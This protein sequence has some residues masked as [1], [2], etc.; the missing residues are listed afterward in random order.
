M[1]EVR[2][3]ITA[4]RRAPLKSGQMRV[5]G[6]VT[7]THV[8]VQGDRRF[9]L[10]DPDSLEM[11]TLRDGSADMRRMLVALSVSED[12]RWVRFRNTAA[13]GGA[14]QIT[15]DLTS[16]GDYQEV[17]VVVHG[18]ARQALRLGRT[19]PDWLEARFGI[20]CLVVMADP[21]WLSHD[22]KADKGTLEDEYGRIAFADAG[23]VSFVTRDA[24]QELARR[25]GI[26]G[27]LEVLRRLRTN[28]VIE[29]VTQAQLDTCLEI[30]IGQAQFRRI[31]AQHRCSVVDVA[32]NG[33]VGFEVRRAL[34]D[35]RR[36]S[37]LAPD[38]IRAGA[39]EVDPQDAK[40][41]WIATRGVRINGGQ[42][43]T[44][45]GQA[46]TLVMPEP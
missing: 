2:G 20:R 38:V 9:M 36:G 18:K 11:I 24:L 6:N 4:L 7:F 29:D 31:G 32:L 22:S 40:R 45:V 34:A 25:S 16:R 19:L 17:E 33:N 42:V 43:V 37:H 12:Q 15:L 26:D 3:H 28:V 27:E 5:C 46:V 23:Q 13:L 14:D 30:H 35:Y 44:S 10:V 41:V 8:G 39:T 1:S 21:A